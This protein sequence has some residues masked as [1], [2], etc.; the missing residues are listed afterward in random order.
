MSS[1]SF[2]KVNEPLMVLELLVS[3]DNGGHRR[4][5]LE[6]NIDEARAFVDQLKA[7]EKVSV[8]SRLTLAGNPRS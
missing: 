4:I 5:V 1:D 7:I 3:A 6:M 8:D 2:L